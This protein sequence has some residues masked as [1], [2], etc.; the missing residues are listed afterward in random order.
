MAASHEPA[1]TFWAAVSCLVHS[2]AIAGCFGPGGIGVATAYLSVDSAK[3]YD[4]RFH[5]HW[6][7]SADFTQKEVAE[8]FSRPVLSVLHEVLNTAI[9]S[10]V[11]SLK[12][13][14][15][16]KQSLSSQ[17]QAGAHVEP[18]RRSSTKQK[19]QPSGPSSQQRGRSSPNRRR[20]Q[21][22]P[23]S[24]GPADPQRPRPSGKGGKGGGGS[25]F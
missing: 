20:G 22:P 19:R 16:G 2:L 7:S 25:S 5:L 21:R 17:P 11:V 13:H 4:A 6:A 9:S 14:Q 18:F 24:V 12:E 15:S 8:A 10:T 3:E 1:G 23:A